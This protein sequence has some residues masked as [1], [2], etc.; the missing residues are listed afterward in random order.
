MTI[1]RRAMLGAIP[2]TLLLPRL[3]RAE[4]GTWAVVVRVPAPWYAPGFVIRSRFRDAVPEYQ[5]IAG[6]Q[7]KYFTLTRDGTLGGIYLWRDRAAAEAW[8]DAAWHARVQARYGAPG[9]VRHY[10]VRAVQDAAPAAG[11][12]SGEGRFLDQPEAVAGLIA[13]PVQGGASIWWLRDAAGRET[14][15]EFWTARPAL[16]EGAAEWFSVPVALRG[17][18]G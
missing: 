17:L 2:A 12:P 10:A 7:R 8:F 1:P 13:Q 3:A 6:L 15:A 4:T 5:R 18:A 16:P 9:D 14:A 11:L